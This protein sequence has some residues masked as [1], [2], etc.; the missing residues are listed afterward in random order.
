MI[1]PKD[2]AKNREQRTGVG[3]IPQ[4][5]ERIDFIPSAELSVILSYRSIIDYD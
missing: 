2:E 1:A 4:A 3:H 5:L